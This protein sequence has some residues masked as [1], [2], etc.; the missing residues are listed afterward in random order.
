MMLVLPPTRFAVASQLGGAIT[1]AILPGG[2]LTDRDFGAFGDDGNG[3]TFADTQGDTAANGVTDTNGDTDTDTDTNTTTDRADGCDAD[4]TAD[5]C[6][7]TGEDDPTSAEG[8][9]TAGDACVDPRAGVA[10]DVAVSYPGADNPDYFNFSALPCVAG[11]APLDLECQTARDVTET[12]SLVVGGTGRPL[13]WAGGDD[14]LLSTSWDF[15]ERFGIRQV[16]IVVRSPDEALLL[17]AA[18]DSDQPLPTM[19]APLRTALDD[20]ACGSTAEDDSYLGVMTYELDGSSLSLVG[21][22]QGRLDSPG[23]TFEVHQL[24]STVGLSEHTFVDL[25]FV[26]VRIDA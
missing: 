18:G 26:M 2:C 3:T 5:G 9:P 25:T 24:G 4:G 23:A 22:D 21:N 16:R 8:D 1:I 14:V 19:I 12:I 15:D 10:L 20:D 11:K 17:V 6:P 13:P 7:D